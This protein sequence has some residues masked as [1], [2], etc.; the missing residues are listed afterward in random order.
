MKQTQ[1][2]TY[3]EITFLRVQQHVKVTYWLDVKFVATF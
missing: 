2:N 3:H 1:R